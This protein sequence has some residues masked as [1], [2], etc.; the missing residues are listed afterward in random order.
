MFQGQ[1]LA[2]VCKSRAGHLGYSRRHP[3][4]RRLGL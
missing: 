2:R 1:S 4:S 3:R